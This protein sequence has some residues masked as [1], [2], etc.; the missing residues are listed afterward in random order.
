MIDIFGT[1]ASIFTGAGTI[2]DEVV[3]TKEEKILAKAKLLEVQ[4]AL[5]SKIVEF[6][7]TLV[8]AQQSVIVA[9]AQGSSWLQKNWRPG[10]MAMFG[11][12]IFNNFVLYPYLRLVWVDAPVLEVPEHLWALLKLGISGYIVSRGAEKVTKELKKKK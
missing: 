1:I 4:N 6:N 10:L 12:I 11:F 5:S 3:T 2:L 9:E 7:T 8:N